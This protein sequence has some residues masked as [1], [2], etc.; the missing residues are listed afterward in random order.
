MVQREYTRLSVVTQ[1]T[2][3]NPTVNTTNAQPLAKRRTPSAACLGKPYRTPTPKR[4]VGSTRTREL[5]P[6]EF[7]E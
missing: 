1:P 7:V 5:L 4:G 6:N 3:V 2:N